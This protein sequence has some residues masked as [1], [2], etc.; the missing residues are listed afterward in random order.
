MNGFSLPPLRGFRTAMLLCLCAFGVMPLD[1]C[2]S[3]ATTARKVVTGVY[4]ALG[5]ATVVARPALQQCESKAIADKSDA[6][7]ANCVAWQQGLSKA[8]Q[9]TVDAASATSAAIDAGEAIASK[10]YT[11]AL[12][13]LYGAAVQLANALVAAGIKL[14]VSLP[15]VN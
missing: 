11:S 3:S 10:D 14:P 1:G 9:A 15:G 5:A 2:A 8:M 6:E 4:T 13:P 12:A 7:M